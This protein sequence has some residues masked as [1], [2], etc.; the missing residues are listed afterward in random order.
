MDAVVMA[1][2]AAATCLP[3]LQ[4]LF[5]SAPDPES[6]FKHI[7][8]CL[9]IVAARLL[10]LPAAFKSKLRWPLVAQVV[11]ILLISLTLCRS[12]R[13]VSETVKTT[14]KPAIA[15]VRNGSALTA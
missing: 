6:L 1:S 12:A 15:I 2:L 10:Q 14:T 9:V 5:T 11:A 13:G 8:L 7:S 4:V 3:L